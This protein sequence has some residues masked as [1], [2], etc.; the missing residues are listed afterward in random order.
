MKSKTLQRIITVLLIAV[1][2]AVFLTV[3]VTAASSESA[4]SDNNLLTSIIDAIGKIIFASVEIFL[5]FSLTWIVIAIIRIK[6]FFKLFTIAKQTEAANANLEKIVQLQQ[7]Q[8][9]LLIHGK[10]KEDPPKEDPPEWKS[11]FE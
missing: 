7:R 8:L 3:A 6:H 2:L 10:I 4:A 5:L 9:D 1:Y 11:Y